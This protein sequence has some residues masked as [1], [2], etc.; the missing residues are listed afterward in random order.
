[1]Y[2]SDNN[3]KQIESSSNSNH[4]SANPKIKILKSYYNKDASASV[5]RSF[6]S[7]DENH[8]QAQAKAIK[9]Q[10]TFNTVKNS[11]S[12]SSLSSPSYA[13]SST[14]SSTTSST[15]KNNSNE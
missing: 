6:L 3:N 4:K 7:I 8:Y 1:M 15:Q 2:Y 14:S 5:T 10:N 12:L 13:S 11:E 9:N